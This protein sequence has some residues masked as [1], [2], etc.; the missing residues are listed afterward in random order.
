MAYGA[1]TTRTPQ[2]V[3]EMPYILYFIELKALDLHCL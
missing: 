3:H 1:N 2:G